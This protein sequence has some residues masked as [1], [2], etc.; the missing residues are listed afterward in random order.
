LVVGFIGVA[1]RHALLDIDGA[2]DGIDDARELDQQ[3][4]ARGLDDTAPAARDGRLDQFSEMGV[5]PGA[6]SHLVLAHKP[7]ITDHVG[8][9]DRC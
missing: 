6:C 1:F 7:T 9:Q 2:L 3:S 8:S 4:V 5:E